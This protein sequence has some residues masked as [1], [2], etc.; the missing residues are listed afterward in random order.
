MNCD[1]EAEGLWWDDPTFF[2]FSNYFPCQINMDH[3]TQN[4]KGLLILEIASEGVQCYSQAHLR[5]RT[6]SPTDCGRAGTA[7]TGRSWG[8]TTA[9]EFLSCWFPKKCNFIRPSIIISSKKEK[10]K[11]TYRK[12]WFGFCCCKF[13]L[14][15]GNKSSEG[16]SDLQNPVS[17]DLRSGLL[18]EEDFFVPEILP[19]VDT[20]FILELKNFPRVDNGMESQKPLLF[21]QRQNA[22]SL[23]PRIFKINKTVISPECNIHIC[24]VLDSW[25]SWAESSMKT[26]PTYLL[27]SGSA[28]VMP[29]VA[30][31]AGVRYKHP[32]EGGPVG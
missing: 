18:L 4:H 13:M 2:N 8:L 21:W 5:S 27:N 26:E 1:L 7:F 24:Y 29:T 16:R 15:T 10:L 23:A 31:S 19:K 14:H 17:I 30:K 20:Y 22:L 6:H 32:G 11:R 12:G 3:P 9:V 25:G 28:S